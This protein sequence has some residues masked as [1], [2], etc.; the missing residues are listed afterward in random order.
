MALNNQNDVS[1]LPFEIPYERTKQALVRTINKIAEDESMPSSLMIII[2]ENVINEF[3]NNAYAQI[4]GNYD[5]S[6]PQGVETSPVAQSDSQVTEHVG[7]INKETLDKL[8]ESGVRIIEND[9][10]NQN[11]K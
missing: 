3:K 8:R 10:N 2:L 9:E 4:I 6:I 1:N 7:P 5:V 11:Q